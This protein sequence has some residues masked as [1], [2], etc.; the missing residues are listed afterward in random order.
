M[1]NQVGKF[2]ELAT[3]AAKEAALNWDTLM[4]ED[5]VVPPRDPPAITAAASGASASGSVGHPRPMQQATLAMEQ[6]TL[7]LGL[8]CWLVCWLVWFG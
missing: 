1:N 7:F 3:A 8:V 5:P 6:A 2:E 4:A